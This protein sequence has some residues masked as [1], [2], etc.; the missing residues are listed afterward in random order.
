MISG[1]EKRVLAPDSLVL[2]HRDLL[3]NAASKGPVLDLA[4]GNGHN[5]LFLAEEGMPVILADLSET[6]L[7]KAGAYA[8]QK[9]L[10]VTLWQVDLEK[11][12]ENP[13]NVESS[14]AILVFRYL[15][16]PLVPFIKKALVKGGVLIYETFTVDQRR[17]GKPH[18]PRFLLKPG[19]LLDWFEDWKVI[20]YSEGI[21]GQPQRAI[22]QIVCTKPEK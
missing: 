12:G 20:H 7:E 3:V 11:E 6:A 13:L 15:H 16:R 17:F 2:A 5:G 1:K 8:K 10:K 19:E 4:C 22:A 9:N 14:G 18:N 21:V